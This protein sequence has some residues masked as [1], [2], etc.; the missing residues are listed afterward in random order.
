ME[1]TAPGA[2]GRI[3]RIPRN[4]SSIKF[5]RPGGR[6]RTAFPVSDT[7]LLQRDVSHKRRALY[8]VGKRLQGNCYETRRKDC[9][10]TFPPPNPGA[11]LLWDP[12]HAGTTKIHALP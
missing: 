8:A 3:L 12:G 2:K 6:F 5:A 1:T 9:R 11:V 4:R 10:Q 7:A